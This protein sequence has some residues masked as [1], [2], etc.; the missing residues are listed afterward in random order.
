MG[1]AAKPRSDLDKF[2]ELVDAFLFEWA[3][4]SAVEAHQES[5]EEFVSEF[6]FEFAQWPLA[7]DRVDR[8]EFGF[9]VHMS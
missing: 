9:V 8:V 3:G 6:E 1:F 5:V 2:G 7:R 4:E